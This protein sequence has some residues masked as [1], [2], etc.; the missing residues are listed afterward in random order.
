MPDNFPDKVMIQVSNSAD[1]GTKT[2]SLPPNY[3]KELTPEFKYFVEYIVTALDG[4]HCNFQTHK[5]QTDIDE[6]FTVSHEAYALLMLYN[7]FE[8]WNASHQKLKNPDGTPKRI[9][10]KFTG[11]NTGDKRGM[12]SEGLRVYEQLYR[13]ITQLRKTEQS[14]AVVRQL[15]EEYNNSGSRRVNYIDETTTEDSMWDVETTVPKDC[16]IYKICYSDGPMGVETV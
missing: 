7:E 3:R 13:E 11:S 10:K 4:Q 6:W 1:D 2:Y 14:K 8:C 9:S 16:D 12:T 15:R 5:R